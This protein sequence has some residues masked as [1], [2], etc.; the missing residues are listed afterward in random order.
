MNT[1]ECMKRKCKGCK[2][3]NECFKIKKTNNKSA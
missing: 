2:Y 1:K 3:Y